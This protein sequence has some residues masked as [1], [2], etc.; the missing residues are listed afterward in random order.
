MR[1][2]SKQCKDGTTSLLGCRL[3]AALR[4]ATTQTRHSY[5]RAAPG[6]GGL[7]AGTRC[8][9]LDGEWNPSTMAMSAPTMQACM[10]LV[11]DAEVQDAPSSRIL[12]GTALC[13]ISTF[14]SCTS[15]AM[16]IVSR[17][18]WNASFVALQAR[19]VAVASLV[20]VAQHSSMVSLG[21]SARRWQQAASH[22]R[23]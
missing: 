4:V 16:A 23:A 17:Q 11:R 12:V 6:A 3:Q 5:S 7:R 19:G 20:V 18:S 14:T 8:G 1:T 13:T 10:Q 9:A 22:L 2:P 15:G 21:C